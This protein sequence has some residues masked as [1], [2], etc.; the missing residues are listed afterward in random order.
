MP[1][2]LLFFYVSGHGFGHASRDIELMNAVALKHPDTRFVVRTAVRPVL[3][4]IA[5]APIDVQPFEADTGVSQI[6][7]LRLDEEATARRA[8][9]FYREWDRRVDDEAAV[10]RAGGA[11]LVVGD[12][13]PIAFAAAAQAGVPSVA[14]GNFTWDWIYAHYPAFDAI[15]P[16]VIPIINSAY[17]TATRTLRLPL[18]GGFAATAIVL[19]DIPFIARRST[20]D[21]A[22]TRRRLGVPQGNRLVLVS[23]GAYGVDLPLEVIR[24]STPFTV[25]AF[26]RPPDGLLYPD[27][28]AAADVVVSKPGYGIVSECIANE[29][30]LLYTSRG[31]F[32][33]YDIFVKEMPKVLRCRYITQEDLFAGRW[34]DA[35]EALLEQPAPPERAAVDGAD[36]AAEEI[37]NLVIGR[38]GSCWQG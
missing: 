11:T 30:A 4:E 36:V 9:E 26:D 7:S 31:R 23:F 25:A 33:E 2:P 35:I 22:D 15:A 19:R 20:R 21:P 24:R 16:E 27:I 12:I 18:H 1:Q 28:V 10:L 32:I 37:L 8:A 34:A 38:S 17:A 5:T 6:D 14:V 13:P 3:F 29:T